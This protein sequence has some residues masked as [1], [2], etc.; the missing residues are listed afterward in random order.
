MGFIAT[1]KTPIRD[2]QKMSVV[3]TYSI[4]VAAEAAQMPVKKIRRYIDTNVTPICANDV[5]ATGSGSRVG[6]SRNR[7][8]QIAVTEAL[9][10]SGVSLSTSAKGAFEFSDRGNAG[11]GAGQIWP[12]GKTILVIGGPNGPAVSNVDFNAS[13]FDMSNQGVSI[14]LDLNKVVADVDAVLNSHN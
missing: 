9:L 10:K 11:R 13:I 5:K 3:Q 12:I 7:I 6:F 2:T 8:L 14:I 1:I 4:G